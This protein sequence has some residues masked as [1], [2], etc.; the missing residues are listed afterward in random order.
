MFT[1]EAIRKLKG[2]RLSPSFTFNSQ[3]Q[4]EIYILD[5]SDNI[6]ENTESKITTELEYHNNIDILY[7]K[8]L[9][10]KKQTKNT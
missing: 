10:L 6:F 4:R 1:P 8:N 9:D 5:I 7:C 3:K 2:E